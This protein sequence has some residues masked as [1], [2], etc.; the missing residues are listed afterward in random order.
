MWPKLKLDIDYLRRHRNEK[1]LLMAP[2]IVILC[3]VMFAFGIYLSQVI[4]QE[5]NRRVKLAL[6]ALET[7]YGIA[8][9]VGSLSTGL[10]SISLNQVSIGHSGWAVIDR[11]QIEVSLVPWRDFL[12][13]T[14]ISIGELVVK[15]PWQREKR[16]AEMTILMDLITKRLNGNVGDGDGEANS[17]S[18]LLPEA[19]EIFA[20]RIEFVDN[21]KTKI[22]GEKISLSG[23]ISQRTINLQFAHLMVLDRIDET[24]VQGTLE[25]PKK[26]NPILSLQSGPNFVGIPIWSAFCTFE[27]P[28]KSAVCQIDAKKIPPS[29]SRMVT[30]RLGADFAPGFRGEITL[31]PLT[32]PSLKTGV[33]VGV[34]GEFSNVVIN[35]P[36]LAVSR[37]GP[38]KVQI[39]SE[40]QVNFEKKSLKM[41]KSWI[42][43]LSEMSMLREEDRG[44]PI[45]IE[46]DGAL[47]T[48]EGGSQVPTGAMKMKIHEVDCAEAYRAI[49]ASFI[50]DLGK[51]ELKGTASLEGDMRFA[52]GVSTIS[53]HS[54][55]FDCLVLSAPEL[56]SAVYLD[57][58]FIIERESDTGP[59]HIPVD[60]Q[61]PYF[62]AYSDIPAQTRAAF[63][64][65]EDSGF[66]QH[67]G[68]EMS[69]IVGAAQR[70]SEAGR[71]VVGGSTITMQT[72]KNLY[73]SRD[74]TISRKVQEVFLA[75]HIE[76]IVAKE[77]I[78]EIYLN[79]VE[80]GPGLY[81]IGQASQR[82]FGKT[83]QQ[84]T[85]KE[86]V[87]LASLLPAPVPRYRYFCDGKLTKNYERIVKQILDRMLSLG[88]ISSEN[89]AKA[90]SETIKFSDVE[91]QSACGVLVSPGQKEVELDP[92][93]DDTEA[94]GH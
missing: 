72:V 49:P 6:V 70:N 75:W 25:I 9:S 47:E 22:L 35:N 10:G 44:I 37:F 89:Y 66:Y 83:P 60:P 20:A 23:N 59:I 85:L 93:S 52:S 27:I 73:L 54:A 67:K 68:V 79:M 84:L 55:G 45:Q 12:R 33:M 77:R 65:S 94:A 63:V 57:A 11:V 17:R 31:S 42:V 15:A 61:R 4:E 39:A 26:A 81:G 62:A 16:P 78:L 80:L 14:N 21:K 3:G 1:K 43:V 46:V 7:K 64:A 69:S 48:R 5:M 74:K 36:T 40:A 38:L 41:A 13:L 8:I 29:V 24:F 58:P 92:E 76:R 50:P 88:R 87:Y 2:I 82:F 90:A 28:K 53:I 51:F 18:R 34:K 86:S 71:A 91:R 32:A 56:Y 19:F 30:P